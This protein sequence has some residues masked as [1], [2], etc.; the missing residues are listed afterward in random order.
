MS[1]VMPAHLLDPAAVAAYA[2]NGEC[3]G[4]RWPDVCK[5]DGACWMVNGAGSGK[6]TVDEEAA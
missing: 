5:R 3:A 2:E 1:D 4:C 6:T